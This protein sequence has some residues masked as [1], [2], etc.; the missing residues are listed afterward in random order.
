MPGLGDALVASPLISGAATSGW[1]LDVV[2]MLEPVAQ[3][4]R[5]LPAVRR[6][7]YFDLLA[8]SA[9]AIP[10]ALRMRRRRYDLALLPFPATRWQYHALALACGA[11]S[12]ATHDYGGI[13]RVLDAVGN[14]TMVALGGGH[15][16]MENVR[17]ARAVGMEP[18]ATRYVIPAEW[19]RPRIAGTLGVHPGTMRY[20]GNEHRRWPLEHFA[21]LI[22]DSLARG[23]NIRVFVGPAE[24]DDVRDLAAFAGTDAFEVVDE[25]LGVAAQRLSECEVFVGNDAGFAHVA[26]ALGVKTVVLF[27]MTTPTRAQPLG[28]SVTVRPSDCP[29]CHDEGM[30]TFACVRHIGY[31]C[32]RQDLTVEAATRAVDLAFASALPEFKPEDRG[33]FRL[34]ARRRAIQTSTTD[35]TSQSK[36]DASDAASGS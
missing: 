31:R 23:R 3:Y 29:P 9:S 36:A 26:S 13:A 16:V 12:L 7:E 33:D 1:E 10:L 5:A 32:I 8:G 35:P 2:T 20:K 25:E 19:R 15:R 24:R 6:V 22:R 28:P 34:Y 14:A 21:A 4:A 17:L 30:R 27:G 18:Q 11:R